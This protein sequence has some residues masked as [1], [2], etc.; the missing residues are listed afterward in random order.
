VGTLIGFDD[1]PYPCYDF[2]TWVQERRGRYRDAI[3]AA[4]LDPCGRSEAEAR[5]TSGRSEAG[6]DQGEAEEN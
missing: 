3:K 4:H 5:K 1:K 6:R 2:R